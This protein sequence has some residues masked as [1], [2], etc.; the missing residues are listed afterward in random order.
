MEQQAQ[1]ALPRTTYNPNW[2]KWHEAGFTEWLLPIG[3]VGAKLSPNSKIDPSQVG[4]IPMVYLKDRGHW[5]GYVGWTK[6]KHTEEQVRMFSRWAAGVGLNAAVFN[7]GDV[8]IEDA[9]LAEAI[10]QAAIRRL[11]PTAV[12]YRDGSA[13]RLLM[14]QTGDDIHKKRLAWRNNGVDEAFEWLGTG[15]QFVCD[16]VHKSG[17]PYKWFDPHPCDLGVYNIPTVTHEQVRALFDDVRDLIVKRGH[18]FVTRKEGSSTRAKR[19]PLSDASLHAPSPQHVLDVLA[20]VPCNDET[21]P[22]RDDFVRTL[23]AIKAA[24]GADADEHWPA[25]LDWAMQYPGA[26]PDY[27]EKIWASIKDAAVGWDYLSAWARGHGYNGDA[28]TDFDEA[29]PAW[30]GKTAHPLAN[31]IKASPFTWQDQDHST[32]GMALRSAL[33]SQI[34]EHHGRSRRRWE[35]RTRDR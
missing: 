16:A 5:S 13:R 23:A 25:V 32:A 35:I 31:L 21:F 28:Q 30:A 3:P 29:S 18:E 12:R 24:L 19:K 33:H 1:S 7:G 2:R 8:D 9:E 27:I 26:E 4:K 14:Y 22:A 15:Q 10:V 34:S 20:A 11:G 17:E 6:H